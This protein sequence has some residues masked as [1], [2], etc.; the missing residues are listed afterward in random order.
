MNDGLADFLI[1]NPP[2]LTNTKKCSD[3]NWKSGINQTV[4]DIIGKSLKFHTKFREIEALESFSGEGICKPP[5]TLLRSNVRKG[6]KR[7]NNQEYKLT[8]QF[9]ET[10]IYSK[11]VFG[12]D[13]S[14]FLVDLGSAVGLWFGISV[15]GILFFFL[16]N[17][18]CNVNLY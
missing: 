6:K 14:N 11:A 16:I 1:C 17:L 7:E 10:I 18:I 9:D 3:M 4:S 15:L 8:L 13:F 12:Y 2:F 5:Y